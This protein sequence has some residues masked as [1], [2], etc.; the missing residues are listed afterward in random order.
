MADERI[1]RALLRFGL[2]KASATEAAAGIEGM[3]K[4]LA[5]TEAQAKRTEQQFQRLKRTAGE[6]RQISTTLGLASAA[7]GLPLIAAAKSFVDANQKTSYVAQQWMR[8]TKSIEGSY[9]RIGGVVARELLPALDKAAKLAERVASF[10]EKNPDFIKAA[11]ISS[12]V[13]AGAAGGVGLAAQVANTAAN[14]GL[15]VTAINKIPA[16]A[17]A[18]GAGALGG[19]A[20]VG[21]GGAGVGIAGG[22]VVGQVMSDNLGVAAAQQ[23]SR[24]AQAF[25][26]AT[27][28]LRMLINKITGANY[29]VTPTAAPLA[30]F[31]AQGLLAGDD[32][33]GTH[34]DNTYQTYVAGAKARAQPAYNA[35]TANKAASTD[36]YMA[37]RIKVL[38][39][40][41]K[42]YWDNEA[43]Y[44]QGRSRNV[45]DF[46]RQETQAV[47]DF[48]T[49]RARQLRDFAENEAQSERGY[50]E[51][52]LKRA[53]DYGVETERAE[54]DHQDELLRLQS[55]HA[56]RADDLARAGDALGF[57]KEQRAYERSRAE[58]EKQYQKDAGRRNADYARELADGEQA[59]AEQRDQRLAGFEQQQKDAA[60]D[61]KTEQ[62]RRAKEQAERLRDMDSDFAESQAK[63][64]AQKDQALRDLDANYAEEQAHIEQAFIDTLN[65]I[66]PI[67]TGM[68]T[69][70][71]TKMQDASDA[72]Q[73]FLDGIK[74]QAGGGPGYCQPGYHWDAAAK[75]CVKNRP[76]E[77]TPL[78]AGGYAAYGLK[79]T[80]EEGREFML[81]NPTTSAAERLL[82]GPITQEK[83]LAALSRNNSYAVNL[84]DINVSGGH[85]AAL[86]E[87]LALVDERI[88][89]AFD[90]FSQYLGA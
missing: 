3:K 83:I 85:G 54:A 88:T 28:S 25:Q 63:L 14:V 30:P 57:V 36:S 43:N 15:L 47:A 1:V 49:S 10:V 23:G 4:G 65:A 48:N 34:R 33:R 77:I 11:L 7:I 67:L 41:Q 89:S 20:L 74:S 72:F 40:F 45:R 16:V 27:E 13:L 61:F 58:S 68:R 37:N 9:N 42:Q 53:R 38:D 29:Q 8:D 17:A 76:G 90:E 50:Y 87:T 32:G 26:S 71:E 35:Y 6:L 46:Q 56:D 75:A 22:M 39:D 60:D 62:D 18:G 82:G 66:D 69:A 86:R 55:D 52:R 84:G 81:D 21:A 19:A 51:D 70:V 12:A 79:M 31:T 78:S 44:A 5:A 73:D 80:G 64:R 2:D 59:F 24:T